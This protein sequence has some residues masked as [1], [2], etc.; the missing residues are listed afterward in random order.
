M[1]YQVLPS[2]TFLDYCGYRISSVDFNDPNAVEQA[3]NISDGSLLTSSDDPI[4]I[5]LVLQRNA[6]P[7]TL[8]SQ[9]WAS[10]QNNLAQMNANGSLWSTYGTSISAYQQTVNFLKTQYGL[11][12]TSPVNGNYVA[13]AES[14]T[15]WLTI[16]SSEDFQNLFNTPLYYSS[17]TELYYWNQSLSIDDS[18]AGSLVGIWLDQEAAPPASNFT[19]G[20][21][22]VL[23]QGAQS[24][25]N[26][27]TTDSLQPPQV[28]ASYYNFPLQGQL[29]QTGAVGLIEPGI[30]SALPAGVSDSF[31]TLLGE[32]LKTIGQNQLPG[33]GGV[34]VQGANGQSW[35]SYGQE[36]SLDVGVVAGVNPNSLL[37]LY[38]G[39]G[40]GNDASDA[41]IY[42][43]AQSAI[44]DTVNNPA[45]T[46]NSFGDAQSMTPGSPFYNAYFQL[47][48]DAALRNQT[49]VIALG[50]GGSGNETRNGL[51]NLEYN[52]T[53]PYN[54]L[55]GGTSVSD[56]GTALQDATLT[57]MTSGA[58]AGDP[59]I[60][61]QLMRSGLQQ[62]PTAKKPSQWLLETVWNTLSVNNLNITSDTPG[63]YSGYL[64]NS[65]SSG[66][67]DPTQSTP[68]YQL[69]YGLNPVT[70][71][72]QALQG[73]GAPDV[74]AV[75]G[76]NLNYL[77]P[78]PG[79]ETTWASGGTSAA[80]P[81]WASLLTQI[82]TIFNDQGLPN[83]GYMNDLLYTAAVARPG[84]F[85]DIL[86]GNNTTSFYE[87]GPYSTLS[88]KAIQP[89]GFG[90][91][92]GPG[93]DLVSGLGSPNG[94]LLAIAL[95]NIAHSQMAASPDGPLLQISAT[96][97]L[98]SNL[99][100]NLIWQVTN[101]TAASDV[102]L[103]VNGANLNFKSAPSGNYAWTPQL[104]QQ[105]LQSDFDANLVR[106]FDQAAQGAALET[107]VAKD[108]TIEVAIAATTAST[109][110]IQ[111][112]NDY[113]FTDFVSGSAS[114][115]AARPVSLATPPGGVAN[116]QAVVRL[117]QNGGDSLGLFFYRVD[118]LSGQINGIDP[119]QSGYAQ[120]A[121]SRAYLFSSGEQV[122]AGPG[123]G[124][125]AQGLL[126]GIN[127]GDI[128]ASGLINQTWGQTFYAFADANEKVNGIGLQHLWN[129]G[130]NIFGFED[131]Y[132]GGDRDFNDIIFELDFASASGSQYLV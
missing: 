76:G 70:S 62:K 131:T 23:P 112:S 6:D 102:S 48:V 12:P 8:L 2:S 113:G 29:V 63:F 19:Q 16:T 93:Y 96:G 108:A 127:S 68:S 99:D 83:L 38:N 39:S 85:N 71:D 67:V 129:Y 117:R 10:R 58:L 100:Q 74:A 49:T 82:N 106:M 118:T 35:G 31:E 57:S 11:Q 121:Q 87:P 5:A 33:G 79:M 45:V 51:T 65:V 128:I 88:A 43:A 77:V 95:T 66:G 60:L 4:N 25:G 3:F 7:T 13:S 115:R 98:T 27:A 59:A 80:S 123:Q 26:S 122:L 132:G 75:A 103:S 30:G 9:N 81:F 64:S 126:N 61:W 14:R 22:T 130:F 53:Q 36:R 1:A 90:Y 28:I 32:Y 92:A 89:T 105:T 40:Y 69:N 21:S 46:S 120:A 37:C 78:T 107:F 17:S 41:T 125:Y 73:R 42:T 111:L 110:Q 97:S 109:P 104:A 24:I 72:T 124:E 91:Q 101:P 15:I 116:S 56:L 119:G 84:A 114:V 54:L 18:L 47:F 34:Y 52:V 94:T 50:D 55:V 44:W 20:A 86:Y